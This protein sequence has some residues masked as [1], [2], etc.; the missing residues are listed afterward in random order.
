VF[1]D[2]DGVAEVLGEDAGFA[3]AGLAG[4]GL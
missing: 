3:G 4:G 2:G 1:G